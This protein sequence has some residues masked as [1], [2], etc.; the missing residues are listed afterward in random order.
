MTKISLDFDTT[1]PQ[2][3]EALDMCLNIQEMNSLL[4]RASELLTQPGGIDQ[5]ARSQ[6]IN[7]Y[8]GL[9]KPTY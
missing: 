6:W 2:S 9:K 1:I 8:I 4:I 7:D 3:K 5:L